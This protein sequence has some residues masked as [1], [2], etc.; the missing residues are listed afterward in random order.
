M[1]L[2]KGK[3]PHVRIMELEDENSRLRKSLEN[4]SYTAKEGLDTS[5]PPGWYKSIGISKSIS[6]PK[7]KVESWLTRKVSWIKKRK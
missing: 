7:I 4:V 3:C 5:Y 2:T 6:E 1:S